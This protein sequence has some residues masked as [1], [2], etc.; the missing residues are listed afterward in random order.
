MTIANVLHGAAFVLGLLILFYTLFSYEDEENQVKS[1][2][3][4]AWISLQNGDLAMGQRIA[5]FL[6]RLLRGLNGFFNSIYGDRVLSV[7]SIRAAVFLCITIIGASLVII[8]ISDYGATSPIAIIFVLSALFAAVWR[9]NRMANLMVILLVAAFFHL[10]PPLERM[11][12]PNKANAIFFSIVLSALLFEGLLIA[13]TRK[14]LLEAQKFTTPRPMIGYIFAATIC[15]PL[16]LAGVSQVAAHMSKH[17]SPPLVSNSFDQGLAA[18]LFSVAH[19]IPVLTSFAFLIVL[20]TAL[21]FRLIY[22]VLPRFVYAAIKLKLLDNRKAATALGIAL[23]GISI[24]G[25]IGFMEKVAKAMGL[26]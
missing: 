7:Q 23:M 13:I 14:F 1:W 2:F 24:S 12:N 9:D 10:S 11:F 3:E 16:Y 22:A 5:D 25:W 15:T 19:A 18:V 8:D 17:F 26:A 4:T 21:A 6:G 20:L